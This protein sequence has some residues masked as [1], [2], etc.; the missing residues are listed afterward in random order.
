MNPSIGRIV[1]YHS[2]IG[3][4]A[5]IVIYVYGDETVALQVFLPDGSLRQARHIEQG[6]EL[7]QWDWPPRN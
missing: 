2:T 3:P 7:G 4:A 5:A 1:H 6:T